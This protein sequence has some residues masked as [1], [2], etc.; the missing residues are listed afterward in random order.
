MFDILIILG[1]YCGRQRPDAILR[2]S[3]IHRSPFYSNDFSL[4]SHV[5]RNDLQYLV[6]FGSSIWSISGIFSGWLEE[7]F[8]Y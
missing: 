1:R 2:A 4:F 5:D 6:M 3:S 8:G 7:N